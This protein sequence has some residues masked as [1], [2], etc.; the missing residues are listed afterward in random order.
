MFRKK[1]KINNYNSLKNKDV[2]IIEKEKFENST[3]H[4]IAK[5]IKE[6]REEYGINLPAKFKVDII[7]DMII[8]EIINENEVQERNIED[9]II[10]PYNKFAGK[11]DISNS[12]EF[13]M[14]SKTLKLASE[15]KK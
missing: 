7:S 11:I 5:I 1:K 4:I 8:D 12:A 2:I 14:I 13:E 9:I 10:L 3:Y 15:I 6:L